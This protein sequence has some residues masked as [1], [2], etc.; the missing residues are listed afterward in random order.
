M[1]IYVKSRDV[2][3]RSKMYGDVEKAVEVVVTRSGDVFP[4]DRH[5]E[6]E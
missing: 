5:T 6:K 4:P 2:L 3:C 1:L